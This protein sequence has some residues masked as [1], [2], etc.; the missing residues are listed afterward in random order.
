MTSKSKAFFPSVL[1]NLSNLQLIDCV[2]IFFFYG[3]GYTAESR[4]SWLT[5]SVIHICTSNHMYEIKQLFKI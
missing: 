2:E 1:I 3:G 5:K 4:S